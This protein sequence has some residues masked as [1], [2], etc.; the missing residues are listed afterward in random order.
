MTT[1]RDE[2]AQAVNDA[3]ALMDT[4]QAS[5]WLEVHVVSG[6]TEIFLGKAGAKANPMRTA[7]PVAVP[8]PAM[9]PAAKGAVKAL[10]LP[11]VATLVEA[12][13]VNSSVSA[14]QRVATIRV[15]DETEELTA[16]ASGTICAVNAEPGALLEYGI[17]LLSIEEAV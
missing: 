10:L 4:L 12:L 1:E 3:R 2:V 11:H 5:D 7:A 15:L 16:P 13:P 6:G 9:A 14:G 8:A 17:T